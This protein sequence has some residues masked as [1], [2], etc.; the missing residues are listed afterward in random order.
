MCRFFEKKTFKKYFAGNIEK[1][2]HEVSLKQ[3]PSFL[4]FDFKIIEY[5]VL[6]NQIP[7]LRPTVLLDLS[8]QTASKLSKLFARMNTH[9]RF[10]KVLSI[11]LR[12]LT[13]LKIGIK[14][15]EFS[16]GLIYVF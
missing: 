6:F 4:K 10:I 13:I 8:R 16:T 14:S 7:A 2:F 3:K 1:L 12:I 15:I 5:E 9:K 11:Q